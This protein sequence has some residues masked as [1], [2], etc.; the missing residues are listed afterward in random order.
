MLNKLQLPQ[1]FTQPDYQGGSIANI[2][3]TICQWLGAPPI[4][5]TPLRDEIITTH[6][7]QYDRVVMFLID[8]LAYQRLIDWTAQGKLPYWE[9]ILSRGVVKPITSISPSTTAAALTTYWTGATVS[10]HGV[11]AY[12]AWLKEYGVVANMIMHQPIT[13]HGLSGSLQNAGYDPATAVPV[14]KMGEHLKQHGIETH[15]IQHGSIIRSGLSE[16]FMQEA[17]RHPIKST[18]DMFYTLKEILDA[19]LEKKQYI[20]CYHS[21][22]DSLGHMFGPDEKRSVAEMESIGHDL[23]EIL[24][25]ENQKDHNTLFLVSADHGQITTPKDDFYDINYHPDLL[26]LLHIRPTGEGRFVFLYPKPGKVQAVYD[27]FEKTWG[28]E[29]VLYPSE[30]LYQAGIFGDSKTYPDFEDRIGEITA[31]ATTD[32]YIWRGLGAN[33]LIGKHGGLTHIE[34]IVPLLMIDL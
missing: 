31:L 24:L 9:K 5:N 11:V 32:K 10:E 18:S 15:A 7:K 19:P 3:S 29:F 13:M 30:D 1:V 27:Y 20:W 16:T 8:A 28:D 2:P 26:K 17:H 14:K 22:V 6:Q 21:I 34:M 12:E 25:R 4:R 33:P 23:W